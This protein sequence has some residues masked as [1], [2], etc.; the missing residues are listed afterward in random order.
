[1]DLLVATIFINDYGVAGI[2]ALV[3]LMTAQMTQKLRDVFESMFG[4]DKDL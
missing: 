3:G 4:I 2:S 1:M